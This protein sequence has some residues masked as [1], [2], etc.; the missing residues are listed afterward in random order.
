M[1]DGQHPGLALGCR[2]NALG[3]S[4]VQKVGRPGNN[5][6]ELGA[7]MSTSLVVGGNLVDA[8]INIRKRIDFRRLLLVVAAIAKDSC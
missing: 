7:T 6:A 5:V 8:T 4:I 3:G 2:S 1:L